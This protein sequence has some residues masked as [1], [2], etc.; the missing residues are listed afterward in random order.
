MNK[1][2]ILFAF[3]LIHN[4]GMSQTVSDS[5]YIIQL[6]QQIDHGVVLQNI[7]ELKKWYA[8]D[9][10][11]SHGSGKVEGKSG[12]LV[13]VSKGNFI[14]RLHDSVSV[15]LHP[16]LAI[17]KGKLSVQKKNTKKTDRYYVYYIRVFALRYKKWQLISHHTTAEFHEA[18]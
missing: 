12:W 18:D 1:S 8:D 7:D 2:L 4:T 3:I 5:I 14:S 17:V 15:E 11:F 13:S 9:F 10:V 6:N 16:G